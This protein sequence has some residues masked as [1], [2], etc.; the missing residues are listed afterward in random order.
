M[1]ETLKGILGR[2]EKN[3]K[4]KD[5]KEYLQIQKRWFKKTDKA[6]QENAEIIDFTE[7]VLTL[8][9]KKTTWKNEIVFMTKELKK[10]SQ[11]NKTPLNK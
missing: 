1:F 4:D 11:T 2:V 6:L 5:Y 9:V 8:K 7:G 3:N 10:N